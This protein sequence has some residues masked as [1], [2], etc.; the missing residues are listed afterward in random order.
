MKNPKDLNLVKKLGVAL[1]KMHLY[2]KAEKHYI[3][4]IESLNNAELKLDLA[5]LHI[6]VL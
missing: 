3:E 5:D 2:W 6:T 1:I 4:A